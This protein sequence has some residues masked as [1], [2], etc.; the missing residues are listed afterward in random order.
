[1]PI[2]LKIRSLLNLS[3]S[4]VGSDKLVSYFKME[5]SG[6]SHN[7]IKSKHNSNCPISGINSK[8]PGLSQ[9][10]SVTSL[11]LSS[12]V[13]T[14][15]ILGYDW[16]H[17]IYV[18]PWS[19]H[20]QHVGIPCCNWAAFSPTASHRFSLFSKLCLPCIVSSFI[21]PQLLLRLFHHQWPFLASH[22]ANPQLLSMTLHAYKTSNT[23][24]TLTYY[25][26]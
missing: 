22:I 5:K 6:H 4:T 11:A 1:M 18:F 9:R 25:Q 13:H 17:F 21:Q 10:A 2:C 12:E 15:C 3:F 8:T 23:W 7:Q 24:V 26:V 19:W 20:L 16:L 14:V